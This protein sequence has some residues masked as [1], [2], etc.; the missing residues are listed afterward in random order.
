[1]P[2]HAMAKDNSLAWTTL[3][4]VAAAVSAF[5]NPVLAKSRGVWNPIEWKW[6]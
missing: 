6:N 4:Q 1:M 5:L 3:E 2:Y